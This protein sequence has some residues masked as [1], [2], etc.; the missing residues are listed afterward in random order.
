M[1]EAQRE[2]KVEDVRRAADEV[3]ERD[4]AGGLAKQNAEDKEEAQQAEKE[5]THDQREM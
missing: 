5:E 3:V 1:Q 4:D 2:R